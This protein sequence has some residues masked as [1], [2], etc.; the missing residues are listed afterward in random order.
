MR[1][2]TKQAYKFSE[3]NKTAK[4]KAIEDNQDINFDSGCWWWDCIFEDA[5]E[6]GLELMGFDVDSG[7]YCYGEFKGNNQT[8]DVA[9]M[10][11]KNH[12]KDC[13]T[14]KTA[15]KFI[16]D[17]TVILVKVRLLGNEEDYD[18]YFDNCGMFDLEEQFKKDILKDYLQMLRSHKDY[19]ISRQ[20]IIDTFEANEYEFDKDGIR[21]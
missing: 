3:L 6:I 10:I 2:I 18:E 16:L 12:G 14:F 8:A 19:L 17:R 9:E 15:E 1:T 21:I 7:N 11:L 5:A 4:Q 13:G 20:G